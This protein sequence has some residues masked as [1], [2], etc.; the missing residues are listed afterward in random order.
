MVEEGVSE[1]C[2]KGAV[3]V[4]ESCAMEHEENLSIHDPYVELKHTAFVMRECCLNECCC[5]V[6]HARPILSRVK[7]EVL[8]N[9]EKVLVP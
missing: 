3:R 4:C 7:K 5:S 6:L 9:M 1:D 8:R 2:V